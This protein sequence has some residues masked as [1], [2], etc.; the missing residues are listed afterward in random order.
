MT[1]HTITAEDLAA[2]PLLK[3][4]GCVVGDEIEKGTV[5]SITT[6]LENETF[7]T[8]SEDP[9]PGGGIEVPKKPPP[10]P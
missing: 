8:E 3:A 2:N 10:L 5:Y 4:L 6:T 1:K 9:P 7:N